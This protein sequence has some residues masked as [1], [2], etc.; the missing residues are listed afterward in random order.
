MK[1]TLSVLLLC[2]MALMACNGNS[3][4]AN[5]K[6][7]SAGKRTP[8][9]TASYEGKKRVAIIIYDGVEVVDMNGPID[10]FLKTNYVVDKYYVYTVAADR[11][12]VYTEDCVTAIQ[13]RFTFDD[14]PKP[15]VVVLP[16]A[17]MNTIEGLLKDST[18]SRTALNWVKKQATDSS[19]KIMSVCTGGILLGKTGLLNGKTATTHYLALS[20]MQQMYPQV[21]VVGG[22]RYVPAGNIVTTAGITSG[23][24]GALYL[25]TQFE[26][27][28][29]ADSVA[30]IMVYNPTCPMR[31]PN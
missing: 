6:D 26:G 12:T 5:A 7:P 27:Q 31:A 29:V 19:V 23:I 14:C 30:H 8:C 24:D 1:N 28:T 2:A 20:D 16:G 10:V 4:Q 21:N 11:S 9:D 22:V 3:D 25:V 15:D 18:F 13:P 17:P